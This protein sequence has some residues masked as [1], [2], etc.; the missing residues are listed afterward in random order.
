[1]ILSLLVL[2]LLQTKPGPEVVVNRTVVAY[3]E[4]IADTATVEHARCLGVSMSRARDTLWIDRV[5]ETPWLV[6]E[7]TETS[8][9]IEYWSCPLGTI[10]TWHNH[11]RFQERIPSIS[12]E[13]YCQMSLGKEKDEG[14]LL[15][16]RGPPFLVISVTKGVSCFFQRGPD[17]PVRLDYTP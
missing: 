9:K 17:G 8:V 15:D 10:A 14:L 5:F 1:M 16:P 7:P 11:L 12:P 6:T 2:A 3:L 4:Q 13:Y